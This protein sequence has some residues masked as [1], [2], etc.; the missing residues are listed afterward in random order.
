MPFLA[1]VNRFFFGP[2]TM[3]SSRV[4]ADCPKAKGTTR[5]PPFSPECIFTK[6]EMVLYMFFLRS[7]DVSANVEAPPFPTP[8]EYNDFLLW[9]SPKS[10]DA[11][12]P[13]KHPRH[14]CGNNEVFSK[15]CPSCM[16]KIYWNFLRPVASKWEKAGGPWNTSALLSGPKDQELRRVWYY[17][18]TAF[19]NFVCLLESAA[20][21]EKLWETRHS[22]HNDPEIKSAS[23]ALA[24]AMHHSYD[25]SQEENRRV[26]VSTGTAPET[27][28]LKPKS[29]SSKKVFFAPNAQLSPSDR[30]RE[31]FR[32]TNKSYAPG[33]YACRSRDGWLDTSARCS[34]RASV[35]QCKLF[36]A[37]RGLD[38]KDRPLDQVARRGFVWEYE[39][40]PEIMQCIMKCAS[41]LDP[42][43][44]AQYVQ[45]LGHCDAV[46]IFE[47]SVV[48][49]GN[50]GQPIAVV[51][52]VHLLNLERESVRASSAVLEADADHKI[53]AAASGH[54][55]DG[56]AKNGKTT[57][58]VSKTDAGTKEDEGMI[59]W[60]Y[61]TEQLEDAGPAVSK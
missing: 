41:A 49:H 30:P 19:A 24:A 42:T 32:R 52:H 10:T 57:S 11:R 31:T 39:Y 37:E 59:D 16:L 38:G 28:T 22:R 3:K 53:E 61:V 26:K 47:P 5:R 45:Q 40:S 1:S 35:A 23:E 58:R 60:L 8:F 6:E 17:A 21:A 51:K 36:V 18:R 33:K 27:S 13:C 9:Q 48:Q 54:R 15:Y 56:I 50:K 55:H 7:L 12:R 43:A 25:L 14:P 29:K 44:R 46:L 2:P 20:A 34:W 4:A